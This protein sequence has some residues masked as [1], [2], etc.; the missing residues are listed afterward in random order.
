MAR[1][2]GDLQ[3]RPGRTCVIVK[4]TRGCG[5]FFAGEPMLIQQGVRFPRRCASLPPLALGG[6]LKFRSMTPTYLV[7]GSPGLTSRPR[8]LLN[9]RKSQ[10]TELKAT[11]EPLPLIAGKSWFI[12]LRFSG[13][14]NFGSLTNFCMK[15]LTRSR[16]AG[17]KESIAPLT[18]PAW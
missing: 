6:S 7:V 17:E 1:V 3:W 11:Q 12:F 10:S 18:P 5:W 16:T 8:A 9:F 2:L 13:L 4:I 15:L 14:L